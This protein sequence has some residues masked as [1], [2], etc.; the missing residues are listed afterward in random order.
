[1]G[2]LVAAARDALDNGA[3]GVSTTRGS[4]HTDA[5]GDPVP[6]R[7][8]SDEELAALVEMCAGRIWQIN[9]AAKGATSE[10]GRA[11]A[12]AELALYDQWSRQF[13]TIATWSPLVV[14]PGDK[15][16][17]RRLQ[18]FS[19]ERADRLLAQVCPQAFCST[20]SFDGPSYASMVDGWAAPFAGYS[21]LGEQEKR[22]RLASP[23]FRSALRAAP[24]DETRITSPSF[25]RWTVLVSPSAPDA[26]GLSLDDLG[27]HRG[28]HPVDALLDLV[29]H[30]E[31]RTVVRAPLSNLEED[32]DAMRALTVDPRTLFGIGDA[33]AHVKS[34]TNYTYPTYVLSRVVRDRGWIPVAEA[35][36]R[37]TTQPARAL[38]IEDRGQVRV[39]GY[40]DLCVLNLGRLDVGTAE[41][42][43]DLPGRARAC[44]VQLRDTTRWW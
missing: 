14:A 39:G 13:G 4:N 41:L 10:R 11:A 34:I 8:A 24:A 36:R 15:E 30:D 19:G 38:G 42:V 5:F 6:S 43:R 44:T 28:C 29:I 21:D 26:I 3:I 12:I 22:Q 27:S 16:T 32:E 37:L 40:A 9:I 7:Q 33:G 17:W 1:V 20:I 25:R 31:L 2:K 35:V 23:D 18:E